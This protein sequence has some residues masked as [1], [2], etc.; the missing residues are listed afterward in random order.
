MIDNP[1]GRA[2]GNME[3]FLHLIELLANTLAAVNG[4]DSAMPPRRQHEGLRPRLISI[5]PVIQERQQESGRLAGAGLR[6]ADD[7]PAGQGDGDERGLNGSGF[8][9]T[10][11][12]QRRQN[13]GG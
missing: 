13:W 6:L 3:T 9:V 10:S 4:N 8:K 1:A 2:H 11:A 12:V 5:A 7:V